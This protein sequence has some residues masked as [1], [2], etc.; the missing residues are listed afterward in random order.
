[1]RRTLVFLALIVAFSLT[2]LQPVLAVSFS[3]LIEQAEKYDGKM[4]TY[5]GEVVGDVMRRKN[6]A[7]VNVHD[8]KGAIGL[9]MKFSEARKIKFKGN[10]KYKGDRIRVRGIFNRACPQHGGDL[11]IHVEELEVL[12]PGRRTPDP[13]PLQ[14]LLAA[15]ALSI[16][17]GLLFLAGRRLGRKRNQ[18]T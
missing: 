10:Y 2:Q 14:E 12:A 18:E 4:I 3:D 8:G 17:A 5:E 9:W 16:V 11:D 15:T 6:Y 1:M 7:W 13:V